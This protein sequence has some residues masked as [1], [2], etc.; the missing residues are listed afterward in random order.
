MASDFV[1]PTA[2]ENKLPTLYLTHTHIH[3]HTYTHTTTHTHTHT[4]THTQMHTQVNVA[5]ASLMLL[6]SFVD[7]LRPAPSSLPLSLSP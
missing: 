6:L 4:H 7:A 1:R 5:L 2:E 3:T